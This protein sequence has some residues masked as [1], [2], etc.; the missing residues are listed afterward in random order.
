MREHEGICGHVKLD[1]EDYIITLLLLLVVIAA[2]L[3]CLIEANINHIIS[4]L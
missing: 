3:E 4:F 1:N 2:K